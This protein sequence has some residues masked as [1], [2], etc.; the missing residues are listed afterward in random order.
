MVSQ[1]YWRAIN[2]PSLLIEEWE[3]GFTVFQP[4]SAKTHFLNPVA[5]RVLQALH[6]APDNVLAEDVIGAELLSLFE[7]DG[8]P[9]FLAE[10]EA[11]LAQLDKLGLI[12]PLTTESPCDS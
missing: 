8:S 7:S 1:V 6:S 12:E 9:S 11:T 3:D 2:F 10:A 5:M 4:D